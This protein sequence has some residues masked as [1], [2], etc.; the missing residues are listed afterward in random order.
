MGRETGGRFKREGIYVYL[1]IIH[2]EFDRKLQSS[3]KQLSFNR[4]LMFF[5]LVKTAR[6]T[7]K[8]KTV[9]RAGAP[10]TRG[11]YILRLR[12]I[13]KYEEI[14]KVRYDRGYHAGEF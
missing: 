2:V 8:K 5:P 6:M 9:H 3:V 12:V 1:R 14:R 13:L 10:D 11:L 4:E 7:L